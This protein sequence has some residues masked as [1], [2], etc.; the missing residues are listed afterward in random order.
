LTFLSIIVR[1]VHPENVLKGEGGAEMTQQIKPVVLGIIYKTVEEGGVGTKN[2]KTVVLTQLRHVLNSSYD[3]LYDQTW[4]V[5]GETLRPGESTLNGL[6]RGIKEELGT[7]AEVEWVQQRPKSNLFTT[8]KGDSVQLT[9][10]FGFV[11]S[12]AE[13]Q[14]WAGPV[15]TIK[16][17]AHWEPNFSESDGEATAHRWWEPWYLMEAICK[18][19][20][21]FMGLHAPALY[22]LASNLYAN[23]GGQRG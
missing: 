21:H 19:P 5:M 3:P 23:S 4:E 6:L 16:V 11:Q 22:K 17:P 18:N 9:E 2:W 1:Y 7:P 8:G 12:L 14:L 20:E 10:P 15:Y 13:P